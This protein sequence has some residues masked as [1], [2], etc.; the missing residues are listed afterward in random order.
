M[1]KFKKSTGYK[2]KGSSFYGHG[3]S[4]PA[5]VSLSEV[6]SSAAGLSEKGESLK[7]KKKGYAVGAEAA[8]KQMSKNRLEAAKAAGS[9]EI[10]EEEKEET[11][12]YTDYEQTLMD[13]ARAE[14]RKKSNEEW[15]KKINENPDYLFDSKGNIKK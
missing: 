9:N 6:R 2:M 8:Q 10:K 3:N 4:S 13:E 1:P 5:K 11:R 12:T 14:R 7:F 15:D